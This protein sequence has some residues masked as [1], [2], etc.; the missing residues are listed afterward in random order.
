MFL[1][2]PCEALLYAKLQKQVFCILHKQKIKFSE[3]SRLYFINPIIIIYIIKLANKASNIL[4]Q[5]N[6]IFT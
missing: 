1:T 6:E 2:Q 3:S 5:K 4:F